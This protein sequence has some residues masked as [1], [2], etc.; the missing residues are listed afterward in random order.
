MFPGSLGEKI[1]CLPDCGAPKLGG[2]LLAIL[3]RQYDGR[4]MDRG[5]GSCRLYGISGRLRGRFIQQSSAW[6]CKRFR[7]LARD[8]HFLTGANHHR[9]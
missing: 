6:E 8:H 7:K 5:L 4:S 2:K 3:G 9:H 1:R